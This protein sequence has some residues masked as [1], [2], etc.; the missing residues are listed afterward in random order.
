MFRTTLQ[1]GRDSAHEQGFEADRG[2]ALY[3]QRAAAILLN[4]T[5]ADRARTMVELDLRGL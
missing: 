1:G 4:L 2:A 5:K 3:V